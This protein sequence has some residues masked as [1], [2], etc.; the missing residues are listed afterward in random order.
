MEE[1][2]VLKFL[3]FAIIEFGVVDQK[4]L[5]FPLPP[6]VLLAA[7]TVELGAGQE[8]IAAHVIEIVVDEHPE[9]SPQ[10]Q[11]LDP[12]RRSALPDIATDEVL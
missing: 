6:E 12:A 8:D 10:L 3:Y 9:E 7:L 5:D 11:D 2:W 4:G 1:S